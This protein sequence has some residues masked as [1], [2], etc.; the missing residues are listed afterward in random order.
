M[1]ILQQGC[2]A[3]GFG[4]NAVEKL[5]KRDLGLIPKADLSLRVTLTAGLG[6]ATLVTPTEFVPTRILQVEP[7]T[8]PQPSTDGVEVRL[9]Q[10]RLGIQPRLAGIKQLNRMEQLLARAE[11]RDSRVF[12][13]IMLDTE[14]ML[15]G[16][17]CSNLF[18]VSQGVLYTPS[19]EYAGIRGAMRTAILGLAQRLG[20]PY[21]E[22]RQGPEA[23]YGAQEVF[24][25]SSA[26]GILPV[27]ALQQTQY[28]VGGDGLTAQLQAALAQVLYA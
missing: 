1:E 16:G 24:L 11:W 4:I 9:C 25:C 8:Y 3:L 26:I 28:A 13:G 23:L 14:G 6:C 22:V 21:Q 27:K 12:D 7:S 15:V 10:M 19:L 18:W 17:T 2:R 20:V 5:V